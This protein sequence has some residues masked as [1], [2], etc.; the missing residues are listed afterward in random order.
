M[1]REFTKFLNS[2]SEKEKTAEL[3]K[4]YSKFPKVQEYYAMELSG[5][6]ARILEDYKKK[7]KNE[8]LP[9]RGYGKARSSVSRKVISDFKKIAVHPKDVIMLLL[10]RV[11]M[12][13]EFTA[14]YG[15]IDEAFYNSLGSSFREACKLIAKERLEKFFLNSCIELRDR[16]YNFGWGVWDELNDDLEEYFPE[17]IK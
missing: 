6:S 16:T 17:I 14:S 5:N 10:Y 11:E 8:Y 2:L 15:D 3:K 13:I 12:M 9:S 1:K 4:L 7:I